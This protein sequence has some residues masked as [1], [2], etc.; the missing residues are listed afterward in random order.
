VL[1][2]DEAGVRHDP[3]IRFMGTP[4]GYEFISL[5]QAVLLAGGRPPTLSEESVKRLAAVDKPIVMQVFTTPT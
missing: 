5:V 4:A 3:R 1:Y 2:E